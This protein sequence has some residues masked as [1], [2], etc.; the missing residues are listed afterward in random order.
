MQAT[1]EIVT[2]LEIEFCYELVIIFTGV[3]TWK[4]SEPGQYALMMPRL[5]VTGTFILRTITGSL[6]TLSPSS[7]KVLINEKRSRYF[8]YIYLPISPD[9]IFYTIIITKT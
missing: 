3:A 4:D 7:V 9:K 2:Q 8:L 6:M 5:L 1:N